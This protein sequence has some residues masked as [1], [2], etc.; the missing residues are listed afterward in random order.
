MQNAITIAGG[1]AAAGAVSLKKT[2]STA[3]G[4]SFVDCKGSQRIPVIL[5]LMNTDLRHSGLSSK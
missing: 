1:V 5:Q 2:D 3:V 4:G